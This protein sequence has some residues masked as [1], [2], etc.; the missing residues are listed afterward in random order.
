MWDHMEQSHGGFRGEED[1]AP[2]IT[3]TFRYILRRTQDDRIRIKNDED[4]PRINSLNRASTY[5]NVEY[6]RFRWDN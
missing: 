4:D 6:M 5:Y 1:Y 3:G 2:R